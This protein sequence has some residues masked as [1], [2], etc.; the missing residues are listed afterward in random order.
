MV[1]AA[2]SRISVPADLGE[3]GGQVLQISKNIGDEIVTLQT[4]LAPLTAEWVGQ[5]ADG[6][7]VTQK[8]WTNAASALLSDVGTLGSIANAMGVNWTN[9]VDTEN[10]NTQSWQT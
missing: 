2:D 8:D 3:S 1:D 9:Y 5:A 6:H 4:Q 10:A 7:E